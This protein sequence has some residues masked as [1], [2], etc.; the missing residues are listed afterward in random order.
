[1][2]CACLL[3]AAKP[4]EQRHSFWQSGHVRLGAGASSRPGGGGCF[5]CCRRR[6]VWDCGASHGE[7]RNA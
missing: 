1:M 4:L 3:W 6:I 2:P 5:P 7:A